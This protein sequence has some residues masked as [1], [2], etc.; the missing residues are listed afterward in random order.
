MALTKASLIDVNGQEII[1]DADADTSITADTDDQIDF[2]IG[3]S[4]LVT[5]NSSGNVIDVTGN[6]R[7]S[8]NFVGNNSSLASLSLQ[9]SGT[10]TARVDNYNSSFRLINFHASTETILQGNGDITLNSVG[11]NNLILKT[12]NTERMRIDSSGNVGIGTSS[13]DAILETSASATGN[14][15]GALLTNTNQ[16]GTADSVSLNFG[17]GRTADSYIFSVP[18]IKL[19]KE[20]QWTSTGSTVDGALVFNTISNES[21]SERMR[22]NSSGKVTIGYA[23]SLTQFY[24]YGNNS[25][26]YL[27]YF[28]HDGNNND[29]Y[30]IRIVAGTD[31]ASGVIYHIRCDD[32]DG[33]VL[34]YLQHESGTLSIQQASDERLKENIVDSTLEGINTLKNIKQREFNLKRDT[35]KTKIIGYVAQEME[36]VYPAAISVMDATQDGS[37]PEDDPE[38]PYKTLS[39]TALIDVLIKATQEQQAQIEALQSEIN[40]LKGE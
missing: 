27:G 7:S 10:E 36:S 39:K 31:D 25:G 13:P 30:G 20:Q 28:Q 21:V 4:D 11:S 26:E 34:G 1:L 5:M 38:N 40:T 3:G 2:K 14:T 12:S 22:I 15:V 37:A 17:L 8:G 18:A 9:I 33:H 16:S 35:S 19:L 32:G 29:R 24:T 23:G 6:I